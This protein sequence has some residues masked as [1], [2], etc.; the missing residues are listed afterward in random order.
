MNSKEKAKAF[1]ITD[2]QDKIIKE[3]KKQNRISTS[4]QIR[5]MI[6]F[7]FSDESRLNDFNQYIS[8]MKEI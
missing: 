8:K 3:H 6:N 2:K 4:K 5:L 7:V 1:Y